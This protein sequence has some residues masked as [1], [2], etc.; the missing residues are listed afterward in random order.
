MS[1]VM[2]PE[3]VE[4][5]L[6]ELG[7]E[8]DEAQAELILAEDSYAKWKSEFEVNCAKARLR[9]GKAAL[10]MGQKITVQEKEDQALVECEVQYRGLM[11]SEAVVKATRA[12]MQRI[13]TQIDI[14]RSVGTSVRSSMEVS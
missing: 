6:R 10:A 1:D 8:L 2:T 4:R 11:G 12:N 13:K 3:K 5:R 14:A 7:R 9:I